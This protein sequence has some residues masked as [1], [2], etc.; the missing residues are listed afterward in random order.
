[1]SQSHR[2]GSI[3]Q[4]P[5]G[6]WQ[7]RY[8]HDG[9]VRKAPMT[10]PN[11]SVDPQTGK[12]VR[13]PDLA[14]RWL[15]L[16]QSEIDSGVRL[17]ARPKSRGTTTFA[18]YA[19]GWLPAR[20][21]RDGAE[22]KPRT[23]VLY[24]Q[25][26]DRDLLPVFGRLALT[27]IT[28]TSVSDW[29]DAYDATKPTARAHAYALLKAIMNSA[30]HEE[31][32]RID[33]NPARVENG[34]KTKRRHR[35]NLAT[36]AELAIIVENMPERLQAAI[37]IAAW[38]G[39][40]FGEVAE[41]RRGDIDGSV[42][43][44]DRAVVRLP[45]T[46]PET[47]LGRRRPTFHVGTP[48]SDAGIRSV[49]MPES[50]MPAI[51]A[52]LDRMKD[53]GSNALLFPSETGG[54]LAVST[55]NRYWFAAREAA[56]RPDLRWHDLRHTQAVYAAQIGATLAELMARLGHS[57]HV[58]ALRYQHVADGRDKIIAAKLSEL[59]GGAQ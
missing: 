37:L 6:R 5:S 48:K 49:N 20:R 57:T 9:A 25:Q 11:E 18:E 8:T 51:R 21:T 1:M 30:L 13:G 42:I 38:G 40:R 59:A 50:V 17:L 39:L 45:G 2:F 33:V 15:R 14:D 46:A 34:S 27:A 23:K 24:Q 53:K 47:L 41:L 31:P 44:V 3:R 28:S 52:H 43:N 4:L 26:L 58:A 32:P 10:F 56:G 12:K 55:L 7:A 19:A 29:F 22:L 54:H 16:R 35:I 36:P